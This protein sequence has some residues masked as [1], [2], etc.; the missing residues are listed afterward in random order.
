MNGVITIGVAA[1]LSWI[2]HD[3]SG[4]FNFKSS[5]EKPDSIITLSLIHDLSNN[6]FYASLFPSADSLAQSFDP[7][8]WDKRLSGFSEYFFEGF[9][10]KMALDSIVGN[11]VS[12]LSS[13][14][15]MSGS[16]SITSPL[17]AQNH[18]MNISYYGGRP[19]SIRGDIS[20]RENGSHKTLTEIDFES[21]F[22]PLSITAALTPVSRDTIV[23]H[24]DSIPDTLKAGVDFRSFYAPA[25][26]LEKI[27]AP[28][29]STP[30]VIP[31]SMP[32]L[33]PESLPD[34][35]R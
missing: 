13:Q 16:I 34:N 28:E 1:N 6:V 33:N 20:V 9:P 21:S 2:K 30:I 18:S 3:K 17:Y 7:G 14:E 11:G 23:F 27:I 12:M 4:A 5:A 32:R 24:A 8:G 19:H 10:V 22:L 15:Q 31:D 29:P 25:T 26:M 35:K